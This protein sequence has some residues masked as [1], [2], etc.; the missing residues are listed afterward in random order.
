MVGG[1]GGGAMAMDNAMTEEFLR[2][3]IGS[4]QRMYA[5]VRTQLLN[6]HDA[7]DV[8]QDAALVLWRNFEQFDR[9]RNFARWACGIIRNKVLAHH[10]RRNRFL[11]VFR[12]EVADAVGEEMLRLSEFAAERQIALH[13][14]LQELD[15][16]SRELLKRRYRDGKPVRELA[17]ELNRTESALHK[18]LK[19]LHEALREC[20]ESKLAR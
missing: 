11:A 8:F 7:D 16:R 17:P 10:H 1:L 13:D 18:S 3:Y 20:V 2:L 19:K 12:E 9:S 14:C 15:P 4:Q 6:R 5:Y